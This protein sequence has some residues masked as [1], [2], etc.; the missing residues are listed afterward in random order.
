M[1]DLAQSFFVHEEWGEKKRDLRNLTAHQLTNMAAATA[2]GQHVKLV[3]KGWLHDYAAWGGDW[4]RVFHGMTFRYPAQPNED[5]KVR[6]RA[7]VNVMP[8]FLPCSFCS[9]H[10][11]EE[12][13]RMPLTDAALANTDSLAQWGV[14]FHNSVNRRLGK[15]EVTYDQAAAFFIL[16]V[17]VEPR[18][19]GTSNMTWMQLVHHVQEIQKH[20]PPT[21]DAAA[22]APA[23]SEG[24]GSTH[25]LKPALL[26]GLGCLAA[27]VLSRGR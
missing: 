19:A 3:T 26:V 9:I 25:K 24:G 16:D 8:A 23:A 10:M 13:Q 17:R 18:K 14:D 27:L 12:L 11:L 22:A 2:E 6:V 5:D 20:D 15:A 1:N 21:P 4:W 7:F